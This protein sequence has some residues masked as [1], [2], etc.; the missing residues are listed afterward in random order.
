MK[1]FNNSNLKILAIVFELVSC[2]G[3]Q[4]EQQLP[5]RPDTVAFIQDVKITETIDSSSVIGCWQIKRR[6]VE[7]DHGDT[8]V[9]ES[10]RLQIRDS[11]FNKMEGNKVLFTD[12]LIFRA[13][14]IDFQYGFK[15]HP[16]DYIKCTQGEIRYFIGGQDGT[17]E[18]YVRTSCQGE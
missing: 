4:T 5:V 16:K 1:T 2:S 14:N 10:I 15:N 11:V 12:T 9:N 8:I 13:L 17:R 18:I 7:N 3:N 6:F